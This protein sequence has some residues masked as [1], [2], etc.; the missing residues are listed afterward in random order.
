MTRDSGFLPGTKP[1]EGY[2]HAKQITRLT[3]ERDALQKRVADLE[4]KLSDARN[5]LDTIRE[6]NPEIS[7]DYDIELIDAVLEAE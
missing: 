3:A 7:L 2:L 1:S 6:T 5:R 4:G